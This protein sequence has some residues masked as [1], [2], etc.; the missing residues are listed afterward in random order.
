[1]FKI[2]TSLIGLL[3][4]LYLLINKWMENS[5]LYCPSSGCEKV[6]LS[7]Y[8]ELMGLPVSLIGVLGYLI[9]FNMLIF[10]RNNIKFSSLFLLTTGMGFLF[11]SY[12][13]Y[14][15]IFKIGAICFWCT[16]SFAIITFLFFSAVLDF[17]RNLK[18]Y[19]VISS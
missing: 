10:K 16:T 9:I 18:L 3:V 12:L 4:S 2:C 5:Y 15:S 14:T 11:S 17:Y 7:S 1:M 13:I 19:K 8:S 6:S